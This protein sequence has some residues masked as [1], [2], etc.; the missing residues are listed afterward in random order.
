L[1]GDEG[2]VR[3]ISRHYTDVDALLSLD[4]VHQFIAGSGY[5]PLIA[6]VQAMSAENF[7][8]DHRELNSARFAESIALSPTPELLEAL[9]ADHEST[10]SIYFRGVPNLDA[11]IDRIS[12]SQAL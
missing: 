11:V 8:K 6:E 1:E 9:R 12:E 5:E 4:H 10:S 3:R 7:S 2:A